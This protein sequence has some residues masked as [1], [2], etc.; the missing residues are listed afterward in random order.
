MKKLYYPDGE[1]VQIG[2]IIWTSEGI[3]V[4]EVTQIVTKEHPRYAEFGRK[5][6]IWTR[7]IGKKKYTSDEAL[8]CEGFTEEKVFKPFGIGKLSICELSFLELMY[9]LFE[10]QMNLELIDS[11][12]LYFP[13]WLPEKTE[14]GEWNFIWYLLVNKDYPPQL[15]TELFYRFHPN[16][17][18]FELL[19]D[20]TRKRVCSA[21]WC[22]AAN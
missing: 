3:N 4:R 16:L 17:L 22:Q 7:Y 11:E 14:D 20:E 5:G 12:L 19:D 6:I 21:N 9:R 15:D 13:I 2:D 1:E 10:K 18:S 8:G